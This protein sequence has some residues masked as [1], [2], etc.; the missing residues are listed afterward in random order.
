M[1]VFILIMTMTRA[2]H[3]QEFNT[4]EACERAAAAYKS[5]A[6]WGNVFNATCVEKGQAK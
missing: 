2:I 1:T 6:P 5:I 3:T 4:L